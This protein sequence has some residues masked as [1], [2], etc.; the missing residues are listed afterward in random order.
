MN[1]ML[2]VF[3]GNYGIADDFERGLIFYSF[4]G[5]SLSLSFGVIPFV[6][7]ALLIAICKKHFMKYINTVSWYW[8]ISIEPFMAFGY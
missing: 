2:A 1:R 4:N 5:Y 6:A 3:V 7:L 8:L